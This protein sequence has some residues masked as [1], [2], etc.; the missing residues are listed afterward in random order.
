[1]PLIFGMNTI[2]GTGAGGLRDT[3]E[4]MDYCAKKGIKP[5]TELVCNS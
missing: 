4:V 3:Q 2:T 5:D 1:M